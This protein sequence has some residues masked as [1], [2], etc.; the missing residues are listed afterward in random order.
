MIREYFGARQ[1][2]HAVAVDH[3]ARA[4]DRLGWPGFNIA[5]PCAPYPFAWAAHLE[6]GNT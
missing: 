4:V 2:R 5:G 6:K 3:A 1:N